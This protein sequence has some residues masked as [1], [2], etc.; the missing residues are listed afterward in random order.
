VA[1]IYIFF[2]FLQAGD[3]RARNKRLLREWGQ[4]K[5]DRLDGAEQRKR[6]EIKNEILHVDKEWL[7]LLGERLELLSHE[8][9]DAGEFHSTLTGLL[10]EKIRLLE[11]VK[12]GPDERESAPAGVWRDSLPP[13]VTAPAPT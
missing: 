4:T 5:E 10:T 13:G 11:F 9:I 8:P 3:L 6:E 7:A 12:L 2:C 1:L